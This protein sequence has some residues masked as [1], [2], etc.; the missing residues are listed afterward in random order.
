MTRGK[1]KS[2]L[3]VLG[4]QEERHGLL[5]ED[6]DTKLAAYV[7]L[8]AAAATDAKLLGIVNTA[9]DHG[10]LK[11]GRHVHAALVLEDLKRIIVNTVERLGIKGF[12]IVNGHGGNRLITEHLPALEKLLGVKIL[13]NNAVVE[14]E[15]A[16]AATG[17]CS[18]AAAAGFC[19]P[20]I[21]EGQ[22]DFERFPEVGFIGLREAHVNKRIKELAEKTKKEGVKID[23]ELGKRLLEQAAESVVGDIRRL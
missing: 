8:K 17:E 19:D 22:K 5:P 14:V 20:S 1:G 4:S 7:A 10:Y 16:H 9:T 2:G 11:H 12:V 21:A 23:L 15:G 3:I 6:T 18:M 13:F